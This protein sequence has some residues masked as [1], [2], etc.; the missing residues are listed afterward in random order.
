MAKKSDLKNIAKLFEVGLN[1]T[2]GLSPTEKEIFSSRM[3]TVWCE[4]FG[5]KY[6]D[7]Y[8][9]NITGNG[10]EGELGAEFLN[11]FNELFGNSDPTGNN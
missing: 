3:A 7:L 2:K 11:K 8:I 1:I 5:S 6:L 10:Q 9:P 4:T